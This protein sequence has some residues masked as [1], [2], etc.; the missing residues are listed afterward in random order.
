RFGERTLGRR[1]RCDRLLER[2]LLAV[3]SVENAGFVEVDVAVDEARDQQPA[4]EALFGRVGD[5]ALGDLD[6]AAARDGDVD[7]RLLVGPPTLTQEEI[8]S[9]G[10]PRRAC[11]VPLRDPLRALPIRPAS[12][13]RP[14]AV[15][16]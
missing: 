3:A 7:G 2:A 8:E 10:A 5:D 6:D 11:L 4:I 14:R 1:N 16:P 13:S 12:L 9:P 15:P